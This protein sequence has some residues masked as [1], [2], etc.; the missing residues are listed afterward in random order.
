MVYGP[1]AVLC[2]SHAISVEACHSNILIQVAAVYSE[3]L[4]EL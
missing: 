3:L 1:L 4:A 2:G